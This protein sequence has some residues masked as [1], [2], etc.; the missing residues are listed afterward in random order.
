MNLPPAKFFLFGKLV[1]SIWLISN[2]CEFKVVLL[3]Q[4][5]SL[6]PG[7]FHFP[8]SR[9][10][11]YFSNFTVCKGCLGPCENVDFD[12]TVGLG[13]RLRFCVAEK[14]QGEYN[15]NSETC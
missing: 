10:K 4:L 11:Q 8:Q 1:Y 7:E 3:K 6:V 14:L 2:V 12:S 13:W 15:I 5:S 9:L